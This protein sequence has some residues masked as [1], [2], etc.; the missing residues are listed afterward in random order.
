[1][2]VHDLVL[3]EPGAYADLSPDDVQRTVDAAVDAF[4]GRYAGVAKCAIVIGRL[5]Y[6]VARQFCFSLEH[7]QRIILPAFAFLDCPH[8][9]EWLGLRNDEIDRA[10]VDIG[11]L[12]RQAWPDP[13]PRNETT[14]LS[15]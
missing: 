11:I 3:Y 14:A 13:A 15:R 8:A 12:A 5:N 2:G 9:L 6:S 10:L 7:E 4:P 1:A